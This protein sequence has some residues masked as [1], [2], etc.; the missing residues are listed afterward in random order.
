MQKIVSNSKQQP[1]VLRR[2]G[3]SSFFGKEI[4]SK[5]KQ[6]PKETHLPKSSL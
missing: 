4:V 6:Q 5:S 1:K 3:I 2:Y